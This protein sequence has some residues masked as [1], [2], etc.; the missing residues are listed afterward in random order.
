MQKSERWMSQEKY[1]KRILEIIEREAIPY[2]YLG[3]D[4]YIGNKS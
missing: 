3:M 1:E 4:E 2:E